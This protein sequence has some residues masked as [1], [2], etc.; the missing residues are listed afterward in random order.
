MAQSKIELLLSLKNRLKGGLQGAENQLKGA[1]AR[2][3][4]SLKGLQ[5]N[6][7]EAFGA[8][9]NEIPG[10]ARGMELL[11]NPY[12]AVTAGVVALGAAAFK[13]GQHLMEVSTEIKDQQRLIATQFDLTGTKLKEVT[14]ISSAMSK[15][16]KIDHT[17]LSET[18]NAY[19]KEFEEGGATIKGS[20]D[21]IKQGMYATNGKLDIK[22]V[23]EY[24]TQMKELGLTQEQTMA[25]MVKSYKGGFYDD[26]AI[27]ALK[28]AGLSLREMTVPQIDALNSLEKAGAKFIING[29]KMSKTDFMGGIKTGAISGIEAV[30]GIMEAMKG[31]D[32]QTKQIAIADIFKGAGEDSGSRLF[33]EL[34]QG[35]LSMKGLV[36]M[37]DPYIKQQE[38]RLALET[39]IALKTQEFAPA[40][41][42][43]KAQIDVLI[44]KAKL[45]FYDIVGGA[46]KWVKEHKETFLGIWQ[47]LKERLQ[48]TFE[49]IGVVLK[50]IWLGIKHSLKI[51]WQG[52][53]MVVA[54]FE[55]LRKAGAWAMEMIGK[56]IDWVFTKLGGEGSLMQQLF[57]DGESIWTGIKTFFDN[58]GSRIEEITNMTFRSMKI[59]QYALSFDMVKA[60]KEWG[61]LKN[62]WAN[63][64][65]ND[66]KVAK[67][68]KGTKKEL[69]TEKEAIPDF[70]PESEFTPSGT[71]TN[72]VE[73]VVG[74]NRQAQN[75][76]FNIEALIKGN[77]T[78]YTEHKNGAMS[79]FDFTQL[80]KEYLLMVTNDVQRAV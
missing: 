73:T 41:T 59:I 39:K 67:E 28:E 45:L 22:Q 13:A 17:E 14:A 15:V 70:N 9:K 47:I 44:L 68:L 31:V 26:K 55:G 80:M 34:L 24:S 33:K 10:L 40:F 63:F 23:K 35:E 51:L 61:L 19:F 62:D 43:L 58:L 76:V 78:L 69:K 7:L 77:Q 20:F 37:Q 60:K 4:A 32:V 30:K 74:N 2:M 53:E 5:E 8:M 49:I 27:D 29:K 11:S 54:A 72:G 75:I 79:M 38:K 65:K 25:L 21:L 46:V 42:G 50:G 57:G 36:D 71:K 12:I 66:K 18:A 16:L 1:T 56:G 64:G 6:H 52:V 3:K 48:P